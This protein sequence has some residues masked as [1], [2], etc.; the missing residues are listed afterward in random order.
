MEINV[1]YILDCQARACQLFESLVN[2]D[3]GII[4]EKFLCHIKRY[5]IS[6]NSSIWQVV[7]GGRV[8]MGLDTSLP[9]TT[10]H[11]ASCGQYCAFWCGTRIT[12]NKYTC[13]RLGCVEASRF[14]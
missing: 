9:T 13:T 12:H 7:V 5:N 14:L 6:H 8:M 1:A 3:G 4:N 2:G 11:M 10:H